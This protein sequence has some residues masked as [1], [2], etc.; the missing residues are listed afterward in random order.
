[1]VIIKVPGFK[2]L[3]LHLNE[4]LEIKDTPKKGV[5]YVEYMNGVKRYVKGKQINAELIINTMLRTEEVTRVTKIIE[6]EEIDTHYEA[7]RTIACG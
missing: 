7:G 2:F 5:I 6:A 1:M 4:L 3:V